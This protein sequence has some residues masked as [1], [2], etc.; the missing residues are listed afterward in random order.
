[1]L[2]ALT[3][4]ALTL[5][6]PAWAE[7]PPGHPSPATAGDILN[8]P[9]AGAAHTGVVQRAMDSN[10]YTYIEVQDGQASRWLA[11]P[12]TPL[13]PGQ[14]IRYGDGAVMT[15]FMSRKMRITFPSIMFVRG[16]EVLDRR[17]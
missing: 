8:V 14:T 1:V 13:S 3:L 15:N 4:L 6:A 10:A 12:R 11:A 16:V 17:D 7:P 5:A 9:E 2:R